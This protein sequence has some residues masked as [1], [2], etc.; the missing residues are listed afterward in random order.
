[1]TYHLARAGFWYQNQTINHYTTSYVHQID[2]PVNGELGLLW[3]MIFTNSDTTVFLVQWLAFLVILLCLY[4]ILRTLNYNRTVSFLTTF[5]F[6][7][8]DIVI[9]E[10]S[11]TKNDLVVACFLI[12]AFYFLIKTL[13]SE[14]V[15]LRYIIAASF[16]ACIAFGTKGYAY[17]FLPGFIIF[18]ILF[19][20]NNTKKLKKVLFLTLFTLVGSIAF[21][22]YNFIQNQITFGN[23]LGDPS[24]IDE[25]RIINLGVKSYISNFIKHAVSFYQTNYPGLGPFSNFIQKITFNFHDLLK[26]NISDPATTM[27]TYSFVFSP[28]KLNYDEAYFGPICFFIVLP[29]IIYNL[30]F[31]GISKFYLKNKEFNDKFRNS[32]I[33]SIIPI[34]FFLIYIAFFRW[35]IFAGRYMIVFI[36]FLMVGMAQFFNFLRNIKWRYF[37]QFVVII[38]V[39]LSILLSYFPM[40]ENEYTKIMDFSDTSKYKQSYEDRRYGNATGRIELMKRTKELVD[41]TI[42]SDSKL[43]LILDQGDWVYIFFGKNFK[44]KLIYIPFN[45]WN[46]KSIQSIIKDNNLDG[47]LV[48]STS[49]NFGDK[50]LK[51]VDEK[52]LGELLLTI[53]SDNFT[54]YIKPL[55][56][57]DL[58]K[59]KDGIE[60]EVYNDDPYFET[61]FPFEFDKTNSVV[62]VI[63]LD[64]PAPASMQIFYGRKNSVYNEKDSNRFDIIEGENDIYIKINDITDIL[65]IRIDPLNIKASCTIK[66]IE[67][68]SLEKLNYKNVENYILF[69]TNKS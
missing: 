1:M 52:F 48:N 23:F 11:S 21:V 27:G 31:F 38:I 47:L 42:G 54:K 15:E 39:L 30:I 67:I 41:E 16:S 8:F 65:K 10:T 13:K 64:S 58:K 69:L 56:G 57:C 63:K 34:T 18:I 60:V 66:N 22:A 49:R 35:H 44:R 40:F 6:A 17:L 33:I 46:D 7:T 4:K 55:S 59:C 53:N 68:Y 36:L 62:M 51:P 28:V 50:S 37:F 32:L 3:I 25:M 45:Q 20:R 24:T 2:Y 9:L 5:I 26:Y 19:S 43:G 14:K 61:I 29:S 12:L